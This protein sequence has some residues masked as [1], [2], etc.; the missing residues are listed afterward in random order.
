MT[1]LASFMHQEITVD[2]TCAGSFNPTSSDVSFMFL[3]PAYWMQVS[4]N[5]SDGR[6]HVVVTVVCERGGKQSNLETVSVVLCA[7][8]LTDT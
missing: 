7:A 1:D 4:M 6:T 8:V 3:F 5:S 2:C